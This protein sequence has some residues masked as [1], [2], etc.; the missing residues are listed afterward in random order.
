MSPKTK[1]QF[2][3]IRQEKREFILETALEVFATYGYH[4]ASISMIAQHAGI[5]KGLLYTYFESKEELLKAIINE[6]IEK[7]VKLFE[8][9]LSKDFKED[10]STTELFS[11]LFKQFFKILKENTPFWRLYYALTFQPNVA[12][13]I[14]REYEYMANP[15]LDVLSKYYKKQGSK[16]PRADALHAHVLLDGIINNLIQPHDEFKVDE[17]VKILIKRLEKPIF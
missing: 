10:E 8:P 13:I 3:N 5:A 9:F 2:E 17:M 1:K 14:F 16:N 6:G 7:S 15:Y 12:E 4:G 11:K